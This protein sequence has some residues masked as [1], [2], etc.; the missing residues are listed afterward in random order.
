M[1]LQNYPL[2]MKQMVLVSYNI[3]FLLSKE[4]KFARLRAM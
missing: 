3:L 4:M 1:D 2:D